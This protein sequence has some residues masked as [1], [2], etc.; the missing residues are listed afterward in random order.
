MGAELDGGSSGGVCNTFLGVRPES[1][2]DQTC[3]GLYSWVWDSASVSLT[4][5]L[6]KKCVSVLSFPPSKINF[7]FEDREIYTWNSGTETGWIPPSPAL[8]L[9]TSRQLHRAS[10]LLKRCGSHSLF[11]C[12]LAW[13]LSWN[14]VTCE[15]GMVGFSHVCFHSCELFPVSRNYTSTENPHSA[16]FICYGIAHIWYITEICMFLRC[17]IRGLPQNRNITVP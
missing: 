17:K 10:S 3:L 7:S 6:E 9:W 11:Y 8:V 16:Q 14:L 13:L 15:L 12:R 2:S 4:V 5:M 1:D